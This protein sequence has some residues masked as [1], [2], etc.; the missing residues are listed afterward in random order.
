MILAPFLLLL[1]PAQDMFRL[2]VTGSPMPDDTAQMGDR[3]GR[4]LD[5]ARNDP[6]G[7]TVTAAAWLGEVSGADRA[8]PQQCLGFAYTSQLRW[9]AAEGAFL[10]A[11]TALAEDDRL[12]RARLG[13]MAGNAALAGGRADD[14]LAAFDLAH[15][16]ATA[17]ADA[18]LAGSIA[19]DRARALVSL[20]R[21]EE[22]A[23]ALGEA[24]TTAAAQEPVVWLLSATLARRTDD[25]PAAQTFI[26]TAATLAPR[27]PAIGLEAGLIAV[28][29]GRDDAARA[30]WNSV[31]ETAPTSPE[32][33]AARDYLTQLDGAPTAP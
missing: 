30:S 7:A 10:A 9:E 4:C 17:I 13:A 32:A 25:L 5:Q 27:D 31:V 3:L 21:T 12:G 28:L 22:A 23:A 29:D 24:R 1:A 18:G 16:D 15:A 26:A 11:R 20:G 33:A 19:A 14:A 6:T 8:P 2:P